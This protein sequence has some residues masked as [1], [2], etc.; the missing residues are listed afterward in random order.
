MSE[1]RAACY[2]VMTRHARTFSL[3]AKL[4]PR[5]LRHDVA[6]LYAFC[7]Y[8]DDAI[9]VV[10][11]REGPAALRHLQGLLESL[12]AGAPQRELTMAAFQDVIRARAIPIEYPRALLA[13]MEM[14]VRGVRYETA[15]ELL[16]YC[17]RVAGVV[18]LMMC[19]VLGVSSQ[20][21]LRHAAHLGIGF[22][23][24][25]IAR[26][27]HED[28]ER[29]RLYIP[30]SILREAGAPWLRDRLGQPFPLEARAPL[31][32]AVSR[33]L[34]LADTFY[35][36]ADLG[37]RFLSW[38]CAL[39][40]RASRLIYSAIGGELARRSYDVL[41]GRAVVPGRRKALLLSRACL[42]GFVE[43][44]RYLLR[45]FRPVSSLSQVRFPDDVM[46]P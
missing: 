3:A 32:A 10:P 24:T 41:A 40:M 12:Y 22:Q 36:S 11:A 9:D 27:V 33:L 31:A 7:R 18:G 13:G 46:P 37:L 34:A 15:D 17:H 29:G 43:A 16:L 4:L 8:C 6:A 38:S 25:N 20:R 45:P 44:P 5:G 28:W 26:D 35:R 30:Q 21:G 19:H 42:R 23:L 14:D 39:G 2:A 1:A